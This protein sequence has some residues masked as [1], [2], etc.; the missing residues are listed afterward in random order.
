MNAV[1]SLDLV[2][3]LLPGIAA[4]AIGAALLRANRLKG[5]LLGAAAG[6]ALGQLTMLLL[7]SPG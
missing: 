6:L 7:A 2:W 5:A 1:L 4:A 3:V